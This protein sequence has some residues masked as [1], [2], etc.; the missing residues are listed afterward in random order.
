MALLFSFCGPSRSRRLRPSHCSQIDE[1]VARR[2]AHSA[3]NTSADTSVVSST[4]RSSRGRV[5]ALSGVP[6]TTAPSSPCVRTPIGRMANSTV[7]QMTT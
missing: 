1:A 5:G 4:T 2:R 3:A 6:G 7:H